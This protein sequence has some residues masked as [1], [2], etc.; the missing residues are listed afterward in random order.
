MNMIFSATV[1]Y[2]E[3]CMSADLYRSVRSGQITTDEG[4]YEELGQSEL[5]ITGVKP[6]SRSNPDK[7]TPIRPTHNTK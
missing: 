2:Y 4:H 7:H 1:W 3:L 6:Y 5:H